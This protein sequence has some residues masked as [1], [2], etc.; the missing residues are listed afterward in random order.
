M[1]IEIARVQTMRREVRAAP[2]SSEAAIHDS[3]VPSG[4]SERNNVLFD[5]CAAY[6][7]MTG[8]KRWQEFSLADCLKTSDRVRASVPERS[9]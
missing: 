8:A 6:P 3:L 7:K 2:P 1:I 5:L 9:F 4:V